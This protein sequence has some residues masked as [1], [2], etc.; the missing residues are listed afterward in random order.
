MKVG[1]DMK[2]DAHIKKDVKYKQG[3][4]LTATLSDGAMIMYINK[5]I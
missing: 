3:W 5:F 2:K 4:P 1:V